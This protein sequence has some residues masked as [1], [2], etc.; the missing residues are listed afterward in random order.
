MRKRPLLPA[1]EPRS[2]VLIGRSDEST[3]GVH[4][5]A[6]AR[7]DL[8]VPHSLAT[9]EQD[10]GR[11]GKSRSLVEKHVHVRRERAHIGER[12]AFDANVGRPS[13]TNSVR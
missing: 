10:V 3:D 2:H 13:C 9:S 5:E 4:I 1:L 6:I 8:H 11:V 12:G 7:P